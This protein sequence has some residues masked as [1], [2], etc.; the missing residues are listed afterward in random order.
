MEGPIVARRLI[1][2]LPEAETCGRVIIVPAL[3]PPAVQ[4]WSRNT[5]VNGLN[6]NRV[7]PGRA[8]GS[9][10]ER[11]ADAVS[12][13]S[14]PMA[15]TVFDLHSFGPTWDFPPASTTHPIAD[16]DLMAKTVRMAEAFKFPMTLVW[17]YDDIPGV[18]DIV[19]QNHGKVFVCA[20]LGSGTVCSDSLAIYEAGV[21]NGLIALGLVEGKAAYPTFRQQNSSQTL[22]TL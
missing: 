14:L 18:F 21:R 1:D 12:R 20:E 10:T 3:H 22:E 13:L 9:V 2:W 5:P 7:F 4:A 11:I 16:A 15:E 6:L 17:E 8:D 19:A